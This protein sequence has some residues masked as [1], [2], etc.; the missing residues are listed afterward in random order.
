[1]DDRTFYCLSYLFFCL[2][3]FAAFAITVWRM[4]RRA[5]RN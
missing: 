1:M 4:N 2:A 3:L 5:K